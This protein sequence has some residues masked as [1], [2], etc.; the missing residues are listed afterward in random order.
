MFAGRRGE[1]TEEVM[2]LGVLLNPA[3]YSFHYQAVDGPMIW[4]KDLHPGHEA[5]LGCEEHIHLN[6]NDQDDRQAF[7]AVE[8]DEVMEEIAEYQSAGRLPLARALEMRNE[9]RA[10]TPSPATEAHEPQLCAPHMWFL[11]FLRRAQLGRK[12]SIVRISRGKA[13]SH[14]AW[15]E[16]VGGP[17]NLIDKLSREAVEQGSRATPRSSDRP[18]NVGALDA[19]EYRLQ[20]LA[21]TT[22][23]ALR[24]EGDLARP[25]YLVESCHPVS[26]VVGSNSTS[27]RDADAGDPRP[28]TL[29]CSAPCWIHR[30]PQ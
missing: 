17:I 12:A 26:S 19:R 23:G 8:V 1:G 29:S 16:S 24:S 3:E 10:R 7:K 25:R 20:L 4:R 14:L 21:S 27:D 2:E 6:P 15:S 22:L 28:T 13:L 18:A 5:E 9:G 11:S 30:A